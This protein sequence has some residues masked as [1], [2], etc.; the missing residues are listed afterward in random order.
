MIKNIFISINTC[1]EI[2]MWIGDKTS[3]DVIWEECLNGT[4]LDWIVYTVEQKINKFEVDTDVF[5][6][7]LLYC[8]NTVEIYKECENFIQK[9]EYA[10]KLR[11]IYPKPPSFVK[12][13]FEKGTNHEL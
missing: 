9:P 10:N 2:M 8:D 5:N 1:H 3:I 11:E 13:F 4:W 7:Y 6:E 12:N